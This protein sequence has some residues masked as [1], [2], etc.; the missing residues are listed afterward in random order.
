MYNLYDIMQAAQGGQAMLNLAR[1]FGISAEQSQ[2]AVEALLPAFSMGLQRNAHDPFGFA[3][4]LGMMGS[5]QFAPFY[6]QPAATQSSSAAAQGNAVL[7]QVFGTPEITRQVAAHAHVLSGVSTEVLMRM[8]PVMGLM[9][10]GGLF[11]AAMEQGFGGVLAQ[12]NEMMQKSGMAALD[13]PAS[14]PTLAAPQPASANPPAMFGHMM[15]A[16]LAGMFPTA[17]ASAVPTSRSEPQ[18]ATPDA[19]SE[20][21]FDPA[22]FGLDQI[23]RMFETGREVQKQQMEAMQS[24][25]GAFFDPQRGRR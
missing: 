17:Q 21:P 1:Q 5:G 13:L 6:E 24:I 25:F 15:E 22:R 19:G 9:I 8:L 3:S 2:R 4:T 14:R 11:K 18:P 12:M 20:E 7:Q 10:M 23:S 16:M